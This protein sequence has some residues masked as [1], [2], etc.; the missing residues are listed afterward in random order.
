MCSASSEPSVQRVRREP[1]RSADPHDALTGAPLDPTARCVRVRS[2]AAS[3]KVRRAGYRERAG[4]RVRPAPPRL[5]THETEGE[6]GL[7]YSL[8]FGQYLAAALDEWR[9]E[10]TREVAEWWTSAYG[11]ARVASRLGEYLKPDDAL[12][13]LTAVLAVCRDHEEPSAVAQ[14]VGQS[15]DWLGKKAQFCLTLAH[16]RRL[17]PFRHS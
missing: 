9:R 7:E 5:H 4:E 3:D 14:R 17:P 8:F 13:T 6:A 12:R 10:G 11:L 16:T 1:R 2:D 15:Y